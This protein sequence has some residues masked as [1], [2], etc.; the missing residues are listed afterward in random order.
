MAALLSAAP[1]AAQQ[2]VAAAP[3]TPQRALVLRTTPPSAASVRV[4]PFANGFTRPLYLTHAH[5]GS[6]RVFVVEQGGL[7]WALDAA[8]T[9]AAAPF[10][11]ISSRISPEATQRGG[12]SERGLLGLAFAPD[13]AESGLFYVHYTDIAGNTVLAQYRVSDDPNAADP[14]S[15]IVLLRQEQPFANHNGGSLVFGPDGFLY[16]SLGDGGSQGDPL[17]AGQDLSTW[18]GKILRIDPQPDGTYTIPEDNPFVNTPGA[19]PEI[20]AY[21]LRNAWRISHDRETGDLWLGDVGQNQWE[22]INHQPAGV[23]GANFGWNAFEGDTRYDTS[24]PVPAD[25]VAPVFTYSHDEG[26]SVTGGYVY[27]GE[28][29]A[30]MQGAYLYGDW[31]L[32]TVWAGYQTEAGD[33]ASDVFLRLQGVQIAS[34]GEDEAGELYVVNYGGS[35]MAL[36]PAD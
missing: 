18:L 24:V 34:F 17:R 3:T 4:E 36:V 8:G 32:G 7:V 2:A 16:L 27:R 9:R 20:F 30:D 6:G 19:L 5:D 21:G 33:W 26:I 15:E 35:V 28:A 13:Y 22:E 1:L 11:N 25:A 31:A 12:Y 10:L 14:D 23:G 29:I